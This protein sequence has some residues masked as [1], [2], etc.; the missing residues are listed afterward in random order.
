MSM[1]RLATWPFGS[2]PCGEQARLCKMTL[3][4][5]SSSILTLGNRKFVWVKKENAQNGNKILEAKEIT[6]GK[7]S[8]GYTQII[9]GVTELDEIAKDAGYLLDSESLIKPNVK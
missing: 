4:V 2:P 8:D 1:P 5:P 6:T 9:S 3:V 7:E